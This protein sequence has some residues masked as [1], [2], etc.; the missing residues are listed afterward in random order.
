M[1]EEYN[2][3]VAENNDKDGQ[4]SESELVA[5]RHQ[6]QVSSQGVGK[7]HVFDTQGW[8]GRVNIGLQHCC[9]DL[10]SE[11]SERDPKQDCW[12]LFSWS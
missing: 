7:Y 9:L 8:S 11:D 10:K 6:H 4:W 3:D 12:K 2:I 1:S 5:I